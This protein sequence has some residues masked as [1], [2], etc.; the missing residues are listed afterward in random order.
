MHLLFHWDEMETGS[1]WTNRSFDAD[2]F[3]TLF[4]TQRFIY[5]FLVQCYSLLRT[6]L[7]EFLLLL[8][9]FFSFAVIAGFFLLS[10]LLLFSLPMFFAPSSRSVFFK[11]L[12]SPLVRRETTA[13]QI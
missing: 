4:Q 8:A 7:T 1:S 2:R 3:T 9:A 5:N 10:L 12:L 6:L 13:K 11:N